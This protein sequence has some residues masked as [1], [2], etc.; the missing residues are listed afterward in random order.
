MAGFL[1]P[2][3]FVF[4][5]ALLLEGDLLAIL[6]G[7]A[8]T[9]LGIGCLAAALVGH[10]WAPLKWYQ[11][12]LFI[13]AASLLVFPTIGFELLGMGLAVAL[14]AWAKVKKGSSPVP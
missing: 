7:T 12:L 10:I 5:P 13:A 9:A 2:F 8:L 6:K 3:A 11:R 4:Q 14:F 1:I